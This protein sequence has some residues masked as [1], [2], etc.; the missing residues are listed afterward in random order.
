MTMKILSAITDC[1]LRFIIILTPLILLSRMDK[2]EDKIL[3]PK[4]IIYQVD[5]AGGMLAGSVTGKAIIDGHYTVTIGSHGKF[6]VTKDQYKA[7]KIGDEVPDYL[8]GGTVTS[9]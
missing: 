8:R 9:E 6:L 7:I 3:H 5:N 2:L 1:L 4:V